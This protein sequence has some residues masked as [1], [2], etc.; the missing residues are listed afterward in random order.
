MKITAMSNYRQEAGF[1]LIRTPLTNKSGKS[2]KA[3]TPLPK[4]IFELRDG[5]S[6]IQS[7]D[8]VNGIWYDSS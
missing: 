4:M 1:L 8:A 7:A 6:E 3:G 5:P 2:G